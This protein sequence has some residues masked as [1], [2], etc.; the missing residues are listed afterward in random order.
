MSLA[1]CPSLSFDRF[2]W[3]LQNICCIL[4]RSAPMGL[5]YMYDPVYCV[6]GRHITLASHSAAHFLQS[7]CAGM[8]LSY[9]LCPSLLAG[10]LSPCVDPGWASSASFAILF[11]WQTLLSSPCKHLDY[12]CSVVHSQLLLLLSGIHFPRRFGCYQRAIHAFALQTA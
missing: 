5:I 10:T 7:C 6:A 4:L 11:W 3:Y 9:R 8:A 12:A 2:S 1:L